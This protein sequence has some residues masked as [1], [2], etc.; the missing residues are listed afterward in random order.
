MISYERKGVTSTSS[1]V[2]S[3]S[4]VVL[5]NQPTNSSFYNNPKPTLSRAWCIF[6]DDNHEEST[7]EVKKREQEKIFGK[8]PEKTIATLV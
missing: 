7:C 5:R 3:S 2:E 1:L 6:Y 4:Q 8:K